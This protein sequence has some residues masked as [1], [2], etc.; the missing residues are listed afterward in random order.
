MHRSV[1]PV[2]AR[3]C[4]VGVGQQGRV[5][6]CCVV[7]V[8]QQGR[9]ARCCVVGVGQQGRIVLAVH[10]KEREGQVRK[11]KRRT[12]TPFFGGISV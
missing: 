4:V 10:A 8:G 5:A 12:L 9:V 2:H 3:C 6:R 7:G 1:R 11:S